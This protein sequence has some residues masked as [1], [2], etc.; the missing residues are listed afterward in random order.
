MSAGT[1]IEWTASSWNVVT[2]C[3]KVSS[4]CAHCYA[5]RMAKRLAGRA[6]YPAANPF[7]VTLHP[8]HLDD[9]LHWR[10]PRKVFVVSMGDL[11]HAAVPE[12]FIFDVWKV[13]ERCPQHTFQVLTKRP[14]RMAMLTNARRGGEIMLPLLPNVWAMTSVEDQATADARIPHLMRCRTAVRGVSYEPAL[15][16]VDFAPWLDAQP[17]SQRGHGILRVGRRLVDPSLDWLIAGGESGPKARPAHPQWFRDVRDQCAAAGVPF[18]FKQQGEWTWERP[19]SILQ[20]STGFIHRDGRF[21][22]GR[23]D[24]VAAGH[25]QPVYRVGKRAAGHLLDGVEHRE[26]PR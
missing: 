26:W 3:T 18:F 13:M 8:E 25:W 4:G 7:T 23:H 14:E 11:F 22:P 16:G 21:T 1:R 2:G 20:P 5:E 6:G 17:V 15:G 12:M 19:G 24:E 10:K 9:P